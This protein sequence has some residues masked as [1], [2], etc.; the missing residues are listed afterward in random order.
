[1]CC[2]FC[3]LKVPFRVQQISSSSSSKF[4]F[5]NTF[6]LVLYCFALVLYHTLLSSDI[7]KPASLMLVFMLGRQAWYKSEVFFFSFLFF[8]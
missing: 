7:T 8:S 3:E 4:V 5:G 6:H 2:Y 1:M